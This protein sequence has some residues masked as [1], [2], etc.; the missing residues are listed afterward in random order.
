[1]V[2]GN[3]GE[4]NDVT[5]VEAKAASHIQRRETRMLL[6]ISNK[7]WR[8]MRDPSNTTIG[9]GSQD[10]MSVPYGAGLMENDRRN[11]SIFCILSTMVCT[12]P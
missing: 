6:Y 11:V 10:E 4:T 9:L 12:I 1:M 3:V 2:D 5:L 7:M 8:G